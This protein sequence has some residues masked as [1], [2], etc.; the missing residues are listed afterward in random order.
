MDLQPICQALQLDNVQVF[1]VQVH[2]AGTAD[3]LYVLHAVILAG[4]MG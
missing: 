3:N 4:P 2:F 1:K